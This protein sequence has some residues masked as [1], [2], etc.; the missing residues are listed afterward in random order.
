[1]GEEL[2]KPVISYVVSRHNQIQFF[3][4]EL[5]NIA[6]IVKSFV[7][8][9][10]AKSIIEACAAAAFMAGSLLI[11]FHS[12]RRPTMLYYGGVGLTAGGL[13]LFAAGYSITGLAVALA[14]LETTR[15]GMMAITSH[16]EA[17]LIDRRRVSLFTR[18]SLRVAAV[19]FGWYVKMLGQF[20]R[21]FYRLG[22]FINTRPFLTSALIKAPLRLE[23]VVKKILAGDVVGTCAGM[24][25][26]I[27]GDGCLA[28]NDERLRVRLQRFCRADS[29]PG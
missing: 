27:L 4:Y 11:W 18:K 19:V 9:G 23:F 7:S 13:F 2:V 16:C 24:S 17:A 8:E 25:W 14:S 29:Q 5:A 20:T 22:E 3:G 12:E 26:M 21:R 6:L 10:E 28:L 15:G 1:M